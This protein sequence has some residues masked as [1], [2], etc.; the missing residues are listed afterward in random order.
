MSQAK[1]VIGL[2][3]GSYSVKLV[4]LSRRGGGFHLLAGVEEE[5]FD[6]GGADPGK[7]V[8]AIREVFRRAGLKPGRGPEV[9]TSVGGS[10]TAIKQVEFPPLTEAE[11]R[12]S[13]KWQAKKYLPFGAESAV[14]EYQILGKD[15][16]SKSMS[17]L[18][19]A[20][21]KTHLDEHQQLLE[22]TGIEPTIVDLDPLAM[23]NAFLAT[24]DLVE[25]KAVMVL[26]LGASKTTLN[27]FSLNG[28]FFTRETPLSGHRLTSELQG[29]LNLKYEEAEKIKREGDS[30]GK[31]LDILKEPLKQLTYEIRRS[32]SYYE[33]RTGGKDFHKLYLAGG[34][35]RLPN[36]ASHLQSTL[37]VSV[38][39]LNP[40]KG[41]EVEAEGEEPRAAAPQLALAFGLAMRGVGGK[42]V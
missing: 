15:K 24:Q 35:S 3:I 42:S 28:L 17:V 37:G 4:H 1:S 2:D 33:N 41:A 19:A 29:K 5:F 26:D 9:V 11:L 32:L 30:G 21:T 16:K 36:F 13:V 8:E 38:E 22:K 34:G 14:L 12:S 18:L 10:E 7:V 27:M 40:F 6:P 20:V 23:M 39:E 31:L 25:D